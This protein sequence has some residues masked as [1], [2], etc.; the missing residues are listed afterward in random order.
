MKKMSPFCNHTNAHNKGIPTAII[1]H[2]P[3]DCTLHETQQTVLYFKYSNVQSSYKNKRF[4]KPKVLLI[5][6]GIWTEI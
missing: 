2:I 6:L 5:S 4:V 1:H 3:Q